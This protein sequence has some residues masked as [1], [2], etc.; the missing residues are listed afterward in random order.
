M[1]QSVQC[2]YQIKSHLRGLKHQQTV[3]HCLNKTEIEEFNLRCIVYAPKDNAD[4]DPLAP[5]R[6]TQKTYE[7]AI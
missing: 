4:T 3:G 7:K 2:A 5:Q 6:G 1:L